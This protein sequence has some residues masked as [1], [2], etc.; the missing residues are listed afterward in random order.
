MQVTCNL[1][2]S[3]P[4]L[5]YTIDFDVSRVYYYWKGSP[6]ISFSSS[7]GRIIGQKWRENNI[8]VTL[9]INL[10]KCP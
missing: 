7:G 6:S 8:Y 2:S 5:N 1:A 4:R 10:L 3:E 9:V